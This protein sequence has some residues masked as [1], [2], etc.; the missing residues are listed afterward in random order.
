MK[1]KSTSK[2][3]KLIDKADRLLQDWM[4]IKHQGEVCE[5]CGEPFEVSH[6][7][8]PKSQSTVL[9][10]D[11]KNLIKLCHKCHYGIH[12]TGRASLYIA[13]IATQRGQNWVKY[14]TTQKN[15]ITTLKTKDLEDKI[16]YY[17]NKIENEI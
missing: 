6:H 7:F 14:I 13:Q 4:R 17:N 3:R 8:I 15:K 5:V 12:R 10:F 16:N 2:R 1:K 9:R 11:E